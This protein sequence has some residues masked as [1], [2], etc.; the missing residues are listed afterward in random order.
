MRFGNFLFPAAMDPADDQRVIQETLREARLCDS[1][2][3][4]ML[5]LAEHH[6]D[7][8]C[9]YVDPVSFAAALAASTKQIHIG[10]A[11]AQ[12]SLHHPIRLAEQMALIDNI[13]RGRVVVGLGR[14]TAFNIYDYQGYGIEPKEAHDRLIEAEEIMIKAWTTRNYE[15]KGKFWNLRLPLL[16]PRP[17]TRP[18]PF[19]IRACSS[20]EATLAMARAGRPF[21]MNIQSNEVTQRRMDLYRKTMRESGFDEAAIARNVDDTWVWRNIFVA[22]T[23]AEAQRLALPAWETQQEFRQA[24]R[25]QVYQEQ[26]LLLKQENEPAARNQVQH[27]ILCGSP[28]TVSEAI[29]E[30]DRIGVG[31][32]ILVFRIGPMP[33]EV[34]NNSIRLFMEKVA[35][36]FRRESVARRAAGSA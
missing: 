35:P 20:D 16:R 15:H 27:S 25:R 28:A 9:A 17:Y 30:I 21:L 2:G 8:I 6:F 33:A 10:F 31:G 32:L 29:A 36:Q 18:H 3:M 5:W 7:G 24:M 11:V 34:A 1:L 4:E 23:D 26:G 22:E 13:S 14:G 19:I 12:M